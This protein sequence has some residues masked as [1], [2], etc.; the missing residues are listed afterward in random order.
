[1]TPIIKILQTNDQLTLR[2][3]TGAESFPN[4]CR[5][6]LR[7]LSNIYNEAFLEETVYGSQPLTAFIKN[8]IADVTHALIRLRN[9]LN[10]L[11]I[12]YETE[13]LRCRIWYHLYNLKNV[14]TIHGVVL[15]S[16][17]FLSEASNLTKSSTPSRVFFKFFK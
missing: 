16:A 2:C 7:T 8:T 13:V 10:M 9:V 15:L 6:A 4:K 3:Y 17:K 5:G 11:Y 12:V 1:M 14:K